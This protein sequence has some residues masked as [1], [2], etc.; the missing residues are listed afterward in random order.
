MQAVPMRSEPVVAPST[1]I[2]NAYRQTFCFSWDCP[3]NQTPKEV[4]SMQMCIQVVDSGGFHGCLWTELKTV[5]QKG[6]PM[7]GGMGTVPPLGQPWTLINV[8]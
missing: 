5:L 1:V 3:T 6:I 4:D 2:G 8:R 7:L